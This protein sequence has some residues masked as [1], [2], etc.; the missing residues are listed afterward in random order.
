MMKCCEGRWY[1]SKTNDEG[2]C[3]GGGPPPGKAM[4]GTEQYPPV[5]FTFGLIRWPLTMASE[6]CIKFHP[7]E[8]M[9]VK[10]GWARDKTEASPTVAV[11]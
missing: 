4:S 11:G 3:R 6:F 10:D 5:E 8:N 2:Y 1:T 9:V 7:R